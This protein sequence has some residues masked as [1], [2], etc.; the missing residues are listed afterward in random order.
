MALNRKLITTLDYEGD[1]VI[2]YE[3]S[4]PSIKKVF[5]PIIRHINCDN[6]KI[7]IF[8]IMGKSFN[9][10]IYVKFPY[11]NNY[12]GEDSAYELC[13]LFK[14]IVDIAVKNKIK[15]IGLPYFGIS[16]NGFKNGF[17]YESLLLLSEYINELEVKGIKLNFDILNIYTIDG[18]A[19]LDDI[20]SMDEDFYVV[21][22]QNTE[23]TLLSHNRKKNSEDYEND[24][25]DNTSIAYFLN[26]YS[27]IVDTDYY[28]PK[29]LKHFQRPFDYVI[30]FIDDKNLSEKKVLNVELTKQRKDQLK[31]IK[32]IKKR[33]IYLLAFLVGFNYTELVEMML[34]NGSSFSPIDKLD[35][36]ILKY[37]KE[38]DEDFI[39][40]YGTRENDNLMDFLQK[41]YNETG[42]YLSFSKK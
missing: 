14:E 35:V 2:I 5:D 18:K 9:R 38:D 39:D 29:R 32:Y 17:I 24:L 37:F 40:K 11:T 34:I 4:S 19:I 3:T 1:A 41:V 13:E 33:Y 20:P 42:I 15:S 12:Y 10:V 8:N 25:F 7:S 21:E 36:F 27:D 22:A 31:K 23:N 26:A 16:F 30:S 28:K 6:K